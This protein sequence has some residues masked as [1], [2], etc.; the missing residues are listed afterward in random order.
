MLDSLPYQE[1]GSGAY[2]SNIEIFL[3]DSLA[4]KRL[5]AGNEFVNLS[6]VPPAVFSPAPSHHPERLVPNEPRAFGLSLLPQQ[7]RKP[8]RLRFRFWP[9]MSE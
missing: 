5:H 7:P 1:L 4:S 6:E 2:S 9:T 3:H 8:L